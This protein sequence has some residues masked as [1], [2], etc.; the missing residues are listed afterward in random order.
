MG[1]RRI[2][3]DQSCR[4]REDEDNEE[5][6]DHDDYD[7]YDKSFND[8]YDKSGNENDV[9]GEDG[10]PDGFSAAGHPRAGSQR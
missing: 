8:E 7:D 2:S 5:G 9:D 10:S 1:W 4:S 6:N 3:V